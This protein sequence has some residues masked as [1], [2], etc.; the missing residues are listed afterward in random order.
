M[1]LRVERRRYFSDASLREELMRMYQVG[2]TLFV[3]FRELVVCLMAL[4]FPDHYP[5]PT[6]T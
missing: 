6:D 5:G 4:V 2:F 1:G 3:R